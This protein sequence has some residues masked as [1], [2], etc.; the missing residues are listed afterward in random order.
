LHLSQRAVLRH[1]SRP[2]FGLPAV[3]SGYYV[4]V[5]APFIAHNAEC[6]PLSPRCRAP[7]KTSQEECIKMIKQKKMA[8]ILKKAEKKEAKK[9]AKNKKQF[10]TKVDRSD[11]SLI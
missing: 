2:I 9:A 6:A 4:D 7:A 5:A 11:V 8:K 3:C 1:G 10:K